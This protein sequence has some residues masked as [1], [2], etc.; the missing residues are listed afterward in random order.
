MK[1]NI[2][3]QPSLG[4]G[5]Y[6][7]PHPEWSLFPL[8]EGLQWHVQVVGDRSLPPL[9]LLHGTGSACHSWTALASLLQ[10]RFC[11]VIPD[12]PGHGRTGDP[13]DAGLSLTGMSTRLRTLLHHL[14]IEPVEVWGNSAG[15]A[16]ACKMVID[17]CI[18]PKRIVSI[19]GALL[20]PAGMPLHIFSPIAKFLASLP[21]VP[22]IFARHARDTEAVINL[23]SGTGSQLDTE[24][25]ALYKAL[26]SNPAHCAS[27]LRMMAQWDLASLEKELVK[28]QTPIDLIVGQLDRTIPPSEVFRIQRHIPHANIFSLPGV[29]HLAHE[30]D[31]KACMKAALQNCPDYSMHSKNTAPAMSNPSAPPIL[32]IVKS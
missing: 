23:I 27:A 26:M 12:L 30:E 20:P 3:S 31:P 17:Q 28:L 32:S 4:P 6:V 10:S 16:I 14:Q 2:P 5:G 13:G 9:L 22:H 18:H 19:N 21:F 29:G 15:A 24:G 8:V 11:M 1:M 7:W 25:I